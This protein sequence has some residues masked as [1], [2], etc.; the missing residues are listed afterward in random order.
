MLILPLA[1][2]YLFKP[3]CPRI[4]PMQDWVADCSRRVQETKPQAV[5]FY[6]LRWCDAHM[7]TYVAL[8]DE[9]RR[10]GIPHYYFDMQEY[11]ITN[12]ESLKTRIQALVESVS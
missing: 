3:V 5:I 6:V 2:R 9:L 8:R 12:P 1:H 7:W 4:E 10:L 11:R